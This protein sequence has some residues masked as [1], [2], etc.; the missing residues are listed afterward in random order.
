MY[1][2]NYFYLKNNILRVLITT[3]YFSLQACGG[4]TSSP[5]IPGD[6][7]FPEENYIVTIP[8]FTI[9]Q[10]ESNNELIF[11][12]IVD[13]SNDVNQ[14]NCSWLTSNNDLDAQKINFTCFSGQINT[15]E[16][17]SLMSGDYTGQIIIELPDESESS[18]NLDYTISE[19]DEPQIV[20]VSNQ[21]EEDI[22]ERFYLLQSN[23]TPG[24]LQY[25]PKKLKLVSAP[26]VASITRINLVDILLE[27]FLL[28][29]DTDWSSEDQLILSSRFS[30]DV[31]RSELNE[32]A[33]LAGFDIIEGIEIQSPIIHFERRYV[34]SIS[35]EDRQVQCGNLTLEVNMVPS[36]LID[37]VIM[38]LGGNSDARNINLTESATIETPDVDLTLLSD[39]TN[40]VGNFSI[41]YT[42]PGT[43]FFD[44]ALS[45]VN[46]DLSPT[47]QI[48]YEWPA[49][50][51]V[52]EQSEVNFI[53]N[54]IITALNERVTNGMF[55]W[56]A[57][58]ISDFVN[59][60]LSD[61]AITVSSIEVSS[62]LEAEI[63]KTLTH[64]LF[65][66]VYSSSNDE[67]A[68]LY[69]PRLRFENINTPLN[70]EIK[71]IRYRSEGE[72]FY[73][74]LDLDCLVGPDS[75]NNL[76]RNSDCS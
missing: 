27:Q 54:D 31:D 24:T 12:L 59:N 66:S 7:D 47:F 22:T 32:A 56:Q 37:C 20:D 43:R 63:N 51:S 69:I 67:N 18:F 30:L 62:G 16:F 5:S 53:W 72:S 36:T 33:S 58:D 15:I 57:S 48:Q 34:T 3:F 2:W 60:L 6:S 10:S 4:G 25:F 38:D 65:I 19:Q 11:E 8:E 45:S 75:A 13:G 23:A 14:F 74:T 26:G 76:T 70:D 42:L 29:S 73:S 28:L 46:A 39:I 17:Q 55:E 52:V 61:D 64:E 41:E 21:F 9:T 71:T 35:E 1:L 44:Q 68:L 40:I 49:S 50:S